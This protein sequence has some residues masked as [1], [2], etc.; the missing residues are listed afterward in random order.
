[1]PRAVSFLVV[2]SLKDKKKGKKKKEKE[3][4]K[5]GKKGEDWEEDIPNCIGARP[6]LRFPPPGERKKRKEGVE[7]PARD[8]L[9]ARIFIILC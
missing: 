8:Q 3:G 1:L 7:S 6:T 9:P 5:E 2:S 4:E